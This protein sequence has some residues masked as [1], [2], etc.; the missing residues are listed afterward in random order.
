LSTSFTLLAWMALVAL[1]FRRVLREYGVGPIFDA[2]FRAML[3]KVAAAA[4]LTAGSVWAVA[5]SPPLGGVTS[6]ARGL[7]LL[8]AGGL[9]VAVYGGLLTAM[10]LPEAAQVARL[11]TGRLGWRAGT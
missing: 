11:L 8:L 9:G 4:L 10:R 3:W 7:R 5:A 6:L 2:P 1:P